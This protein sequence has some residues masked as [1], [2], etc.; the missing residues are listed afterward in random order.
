[1][2]K[3]EQRLSNFIPLSPHSCTRYLSA[4]VLTLL[5]H[6]HPSF[7]L[8]PSPGEAA[9]EKQSLALEKHPDKIISVSKRA[10]SCR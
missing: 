7:C 1:M 4:A 5:A 9:G 2:G 8:Q 6:P 3:H 10:V